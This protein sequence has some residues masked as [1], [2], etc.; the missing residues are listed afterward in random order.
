MAKQP[1]LDEQE[2]TFTIEATDRNTVHVFTND[3]VWMS[4]IEK[5]GIEA[6]NEDSYGKFYRVSLDEFNFGIR[7]RRQLTDEQR[8]AF[9]DRMAALR[10]G[11]DDDDGDEDV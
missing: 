6:Y 5:L 2:T 3:S 11:D 7:K 1:A 8:Q 9:A 10:A 4:R